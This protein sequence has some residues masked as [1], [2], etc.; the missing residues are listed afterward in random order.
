TVLI[1]AQIE[2]SSIAGSASFIVASTAAPSAS[3]VTTTSAPATASSGLSATRAPS[4][5]ARSRVRFQA[6]TLWPLS[7]RRRAIGAP[8]IP[9]PRT[10][11]RVIVGSGSGCALAL[12]E[13]VESSLDLGDPDERADVRKEDP[14]A[15]DSGDRRVALPVLLVHLADVGREQ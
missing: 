7:A 12:P 14:R 11:T 15:G 3:I 13:P 6:E 2:P 9:V 1:C 8:M 5:S 4:P 10:A